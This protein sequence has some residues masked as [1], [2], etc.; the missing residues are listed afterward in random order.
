[1]QRCAILIDGSNFYFKL[2]DLGL[3]NLLNFDFNKFIK[4]IAGCN[5]D[6]IQATYYVGAIRTTNTKKSQQLLSQQRRLLSHL[7]KCGLN[8][9]LG[10]LLKSGSNFHEKGVDVKIAIDILIATY[11]NIVDRSSNFRLLSKTD[12]LSFSLISS[13]KS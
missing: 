4:Q 1:M 9:F 12:I 10:Y 13:S 7:K 11:E 6:L 5:V 3:H 8:Y 2:R